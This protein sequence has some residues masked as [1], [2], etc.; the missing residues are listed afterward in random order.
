LIRLAFRFDDPSPVSKHGVE[1]R[2]LEQFVERRLPA[3]L[4]VIPLRGEPGAEVGFSRET[5]SHLLAASD[6]GLIEIA[7][8]GYAHRDT[9]LCRNE[10]SEL[11]GL[12]PDRQRE[13]IA[14]AK[15]ALESALGRDIS[16]FVPPWN[17]YDAGTLAAVRANGLSYLSADR[18][19]P[20]STGVPV[21][22]ATCNLRQLRDAVSEARGFDPMDPIIVVLLHHYDFERDEDDPPGP[23]LSYQELGDLLDWLLDLRDLECRTLQQI[24]DELPPRPLRWPRHLR[25]R[26]RLPYRL[27]RWVPQSCLLTKPY[28]P[29]RVDPSA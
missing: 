13:V 20:P 6:S 19:A 4:G 2:V 24:V 8:H 27:Q 15:G 11:A 3:T 29:L 28:R 14:Q 18:R 26:S 22:P 9:G 10:R 21:L 1:E 5:A 17:S 25:W 16:G 7:L 12:A 23:V